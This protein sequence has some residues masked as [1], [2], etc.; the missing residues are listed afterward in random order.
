TVELRQ[1]DLPD[2]DGRAHGLAPLLGIRRSPG[3]LHDEP[4]L[5]VLPRP[6]LVAVVAQDRERAYEDAQRAEP[7]VELL[8]GPVL[9]LQWPSIA[10]GGG[11]HG[12]TQ[13]QFGPRNI[14]PI[15]V[16]TMAAATHTLKTVVATLRSLAYLLHTPGRH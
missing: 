7:P 11:R 13:P 15:T 9:H 14:V 2:L 8:E 1:K 5:V 6:V 3:L 16:N 12:T 10:G 4:A